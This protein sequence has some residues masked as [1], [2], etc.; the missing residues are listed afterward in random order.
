[1]A[2]IRGE[3]QMLSI[4]DSRTFPALISGT[5]TSFSQAL[6]SPLGRTINERRKAPQG[7]MSSSF[8][9]FLGM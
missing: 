6:T 2:E 4:E 7:M 8:C 1:M 5:S 9:H 3:F